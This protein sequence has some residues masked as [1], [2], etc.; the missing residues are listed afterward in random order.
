MPQVK[1]K[2]CHAYNPA[3]GAYLQPTV[4]YLDPLTPGQYNLPAGAI[5][6]DP[7][8]LAAWDATNWPYVNGSAWE[9]KAL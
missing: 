4:A 5:W 8:E 6:A 1:A 9:L 3:T 2:V 7:N